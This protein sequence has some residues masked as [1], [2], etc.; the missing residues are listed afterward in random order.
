MDNIKAKQ[1]PVDF[2][3]LRKG[4]IIPVSAIERITKTK[5]GTTEYALT[6]L[7]LK[8]SIQ[9][10]LWSI[11]KP[12]TCTTRGGAIAVLKDDEASEY[13]Y[14]QGQ[15]YLRGQARATVRIQHVDHG[16]LGEEDKRKHVRRVEV[17]GKFMQAICDTRIE[18]RMLPYRRPLPGLPEPKTR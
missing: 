6:L 5:H 11:G 17:M 12:W 8:E 1:W 14:R 7:S 9:N 2:E 16:Q 4:D 13:N 18:L 3:S 15:R 10:H